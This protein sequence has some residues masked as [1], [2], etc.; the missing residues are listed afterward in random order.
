M[1]LACAVCF[2]RRDDFLHEL[3]RVRDSLAHFSGARIAFL[4]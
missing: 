1:P 3:F 4:I 2:L